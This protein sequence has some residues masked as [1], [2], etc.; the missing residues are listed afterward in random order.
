MSRSVL[1]VPTQVAVYNAFMSWV[2]RMD[3]LQ[4]VIPTR[5]YE[6]RLSSSV[7]WVY[8]YQADFQGFQVGSGAESLLCSYDAGCRVF[9]T[10][11]ILSISL[12]VL[13]LQIVAA[14]LSSITQLK[15]IL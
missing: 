2:D 3:Q 14:R 8:G 11:Q 6:K 9:A 10:K 13:R 1:E 12:R 15:Q 5:R 7:N 4:S